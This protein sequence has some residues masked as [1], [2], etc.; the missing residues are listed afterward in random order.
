LSDK[1]IFRL[2]AERY[3]KSRGRPV[4]PRVS[5]G[6]RAPGGGRKAGNSNVFQS[7]RTVRVSD[8]IIQQMQRQIVSGK[9]EPG[10]RLPTET[11][12]AQQFGVSRSSVR[13]ALTILESKG[14]LERHKSGGT[15]LCRFC[16]EKILA[17]IDIP[18]KPDSEMFEDLYEARELFEVRVAGLACSRADD[19]DL[20]KIEKTLEMMRKSLREGDSGI[21]ADVLFH[22]CI[23]GATKNQVIA[24]IVRSFGN[25]LREMR[26]KTLAYPGR[27]KKCLEEHRE[28]Y[29]AIR[30][31]DSARCCTLMKQHFDAVAKIRSAMNGGKTE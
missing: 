21:E 27:L 10:Q 18:R 17:A 1:R 23:A 8:Q 3:G 20:M 13:E 22:Q 29:R 14:V 11:E 2:S 28:I 19:L 6:R 24:G 4:F 12:L 9:L 15:F 31:R 7:I 30:D 26:V 25:M 5:A 16:L